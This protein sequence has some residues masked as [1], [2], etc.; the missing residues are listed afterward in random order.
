MNNLKLVYHFNKYYFYGEIR[1][2]IYKLYNG[3]EFIGTIG[4]I[5]NKDY[6]QLSTLFVEENY[7]KKGYASFLL[8]NVFEQQKNK[9]YNLIYVNSTK[10]AKKFYTNH[11]FVH[12]S[13]MGF[14][15]KY[16]RKLDKAQF[17]KRLN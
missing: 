7:R 6:C 5:D 4:C 13:S 2:H 11:G 8:N 16:I 14:I 17:Y 1:E 10:D 12:T 3:I 9:G 15:D